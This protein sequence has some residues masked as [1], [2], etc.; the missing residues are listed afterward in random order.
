MFNQS[1]LGT[2]IALFCDVCVIL[3]L[4]WWCFSYY[5]LGVVLVFVSQ[6]WCVFCLV[7]FRFTFVVCFVW[8]D[9]VLLVIC[10]VRFCFVLHSFSGRSRFVS[11]DLEGVVSLSYHLFYGLLSVLL[12]LLVLFLVDSVVRSF[13]F[14]I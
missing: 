2:V 13:H 11:F 10:C 14:C 9:F 4:F 7:R 3:H 8:F 5:G 12:A 6:L 1:I